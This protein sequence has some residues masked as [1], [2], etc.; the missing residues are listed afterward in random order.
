MKGIEKSLPYSLLLP[1]MSHTN[2]IAHRVYAVH[3]KAHAN[4]DIPSQLIES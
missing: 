2:C 3:L 4:A 1:F